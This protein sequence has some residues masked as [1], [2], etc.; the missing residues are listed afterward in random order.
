MSTPRFAAAGLICAGLF[1]L[2]VHAA[3]LCTLL[4]DAKSGDI[5]LQQG[6][7]E[8]RYTPASTFKIPL[9]VMGFDSGFLQSEHQ[10]TLPYRNGYVDWGGD[11]WKQPTDPVR[12]L[13]YSVV[14]YSQ[15]IAQ[16]LGEERLGRYA[17]AFGYGNADFSGDPGKHNGLER[18][19]IASS[20]QVSPLEQLA[21]LRKL[22][23]LELPVSKRAQEL[24]MKIVE[25]S[26]AADGWQAHGKTGMAYPRKAD[27]E[28]DEEHP[29]GW[30][31]GWANKGERSLVFVRLIQDDKKEPGTAGVRSRAAFLEELPALL[32]ATPAPAQSISR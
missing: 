7:C 17:D 20:L 16:A 10:P 15:Q 8:Q 1:S 18:A 32:A 26:A 24:T 3:T 21:F 6:S 22:V 30:Y 13:K 27:G 4:A 25:T 31:V 5:L 2:P 23:N 29:Y 28:F 11:N 14:W 12:W 9:S 19:W